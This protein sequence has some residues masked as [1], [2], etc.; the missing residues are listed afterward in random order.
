M[1]ASQA[2]ARAGR[3]AAHLL[4]NNAVLRTA[5]GTSSTRDRKK[6]RANSTKP[7]IFIL[8]RLSWLQIL[9]KCSS[10][11]ER[12]KQASTT[13]PRRVRLVPAGRQGGRAGGRVA[14]GFE[15]SCAGGRVGWRPSRWAGGRLQHGLGCPAPSPRLLLLLLLP[16]SN[17]TVTASRGLPLTVGDD[18]ECHSGDVMQQH[19]APVCG[20]SRGQA[21]PPA[22][23]MPGGTGGGAR[24]QASG[25]SH[26]CSLAALPPPP[27][28]AARLPLHPPTWQAVAQHG[29]EQH[30]AVP[31]QLRM[32]VQ[33]GGWLR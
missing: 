22:L 5:R 15:G 29:L 28:L 13:T 26:T 20:S 3:Q 33:P 8:P 31:R 7:P 2:A 24:E 4:S 19:V 14:W 17:G 11:L 32:V 25:L 6:A 30:V 16:D 10:G 21:Q 18:N 1:V 12:A 23:Q 27:A 9:A